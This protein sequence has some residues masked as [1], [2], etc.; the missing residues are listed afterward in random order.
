VQLQPRHV[1][2]GAAAIGAIA[3]ASG[4]ATASSRSI[5]AVYRDPVGDAGDAP[6][7]EQ[8]TIRPVRSGL[9][10]DVKLAGPT[11]LGPY[12]WILVGLD[13]DR[14]A[15]TG[16]GRGDELLVLANGESTTLARWTGRGFT[17]ISPH[18]GIHAALSSTDLTF[19]LG[20]S[21]LRTG[22]FDFSLA[23][24]RQD[25]DLAPDRGVAAYPQ[26]ARRSRQAAGL[27][28]TRP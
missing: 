28:L 17:S 20:R 15:Y 18:G 19:L 22:S 11:Q 2:F 9:A 5:A 21:D 4:S 3:I 1:A 13:T 26:P 7:I 27:P 12:G 14:N 16:G 6:D 24:L 10:F 23:S 25:A 8:L